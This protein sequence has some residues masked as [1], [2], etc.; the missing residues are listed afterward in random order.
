MLLPSACGRRVPTAR[1]TA[2]KNTSRKRARAR[3]WN[4]LKIGFPPWMDLSQ[5]TCQHP[6]PQ[7]MRAPPG[8]VRAACVSV[9]LGQ[10]AILPQGGRD[11][12]CLAQRAEG[13]SHHGHNGGV[14]PRKLPER[15]PSRGR[16]GC[17]LLNA[18]VSAASPSANGV[19]PPRHLSA[20]LWLGSCATRT[21][22]CARADSWAAA[23]AHY[24]H[25]VARRYNREPRA[26]ANGDDSP[27]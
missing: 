25:R 2:P 19:L 14:P 24:P 26:N 27:E 5:I 10:P 11:L 7:H 13:R 8:H 20:C 16:V 9:H 6:G 21:R 3:A 4:R 18:L 22:P 17:T 15:A 23:H 12:P 1:H